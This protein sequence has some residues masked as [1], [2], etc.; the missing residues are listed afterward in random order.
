MRAS[1]SPRSWL[2]TSVLA[3]AMRTIPKATK[4][5]ST[6][7]LTFGRLFST[8]GSNKAVKREV[9]AKPARPTET[10]ETAIAPK[11]HNQCRPRMK[12]AISESVR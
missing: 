9:A 1:E 5:A 7:L 3:P 2:G 12:P 8:N 10:L 11:K 4:R 6:T